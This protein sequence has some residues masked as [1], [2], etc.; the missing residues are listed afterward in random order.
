[1]PKQRSRAD[2]DNQIN[3]VYTTKLDVDIEWLE[4]RER[5]KRGREH[6]KEYIQLGRTRRH[7]IVASMF[8]IRMY[9]AVTERE[10]KHLKWGLPKKKKLEVVKTGHFGA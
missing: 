5:K 9:V 10:Q 2:R 1:M 8:E 6:T 3:L 4:Y 7:L